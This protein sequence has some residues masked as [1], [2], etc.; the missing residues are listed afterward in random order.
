MVSNPKTQGSVSVVDPTPEALA[1]QTLSAKSVELN[2]LLN[3]YSWVLP[4]AI[5]AALGVGALF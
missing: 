3:R 4:A 2:K 1:Q 5:V